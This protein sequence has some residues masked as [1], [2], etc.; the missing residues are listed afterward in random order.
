MKNFKIYSLLI[1]TIVWAFI[2]FSSCNEKEEIIPVPEPE[3]N[4][5]VNLTGEEETNLLYLREEEKLARDVYL[6]FDAQYDQQIFKNIS[7]SEQ[8]HMDQVL[9]LLEKYEIE[10]P[11][12]AE[13]G[14]FSNAEIQKLYDDLIE[15]G[16]SSLTAALEVGAI[17]EDVDIFDLQNGITSTDKE[18]IIEVYEKLMCGSKNHM[19]AFTKQLKNQGGTYTPQ[20]ISQEEYDG[21]ISSQNQHCNN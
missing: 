10:D 3:P 4:P 17:I 6:Y 2:G 21:I 15:Q 20:F 1:A 14:V 18:Y 19:R 11:A 16:D 9:D 7:A 12:L 8:A 13:K 5:I